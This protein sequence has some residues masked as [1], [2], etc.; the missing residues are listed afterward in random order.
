MKDGKISKGKSKRGGEEGDDK[1][2]GGGAERKVE[3]EGGGLHEQVLHLHGYPVRLVMAHTW[4]CERCNSNNLLTRKRCFICCTI[5]PNR[6]RIVSEPWASNVLARMHFQ[7]EA[8]TQRTHSTA[9]QGGQ[10][11]A[12]GA[13]Q[14]GAVGY[15]ARLMGKRNAGA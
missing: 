7:I 13:R 6:L 8:R 3:S 9:A 5:M 14:E 4:V 11:A 2:G 10:Y 15:K 1:A 12:G